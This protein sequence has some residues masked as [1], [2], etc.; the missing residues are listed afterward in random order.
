MNEFVSRFSALSHCH[1]QH[2]NVLIMEALLYIL[3]PDMYFLLPIALL[4]QVFLVILACL[5]FQMDFISN[6]SIQ[7]KKT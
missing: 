4:F 7:V 1:C 3:T 2:Q 5:F 6:L